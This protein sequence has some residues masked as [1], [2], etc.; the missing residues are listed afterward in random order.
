MGGFFSEFSSFLL[1]CDRYAAGDFFIS[2]TLSFVKEKLTLSR[3]AA[4]GTMRGSVLAIDIPMSKEKEIQSNA[5]MD[6][7]FK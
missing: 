5:L 7:T 6:Q 1:S 4:S 3:F 2:F